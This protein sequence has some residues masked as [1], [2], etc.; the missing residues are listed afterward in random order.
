LNDYIGRLRFELDPESE[1]PYLQPESTDKPS[2]TSSSEA[3]GL[4]SSGS[5]TTDAFLEAS[6][7]ASQSASRVSSEPSPATGSAPKSAPES[8]PGSSSPAG[9]KSTSPADSKVAPESYLFLH[10][11]GLKHLRGDVAKAIMKSRKKSA[12]QRDAAPAKPEGKAGPLSGEVRVRSRDSANGNQ[13]HLPLS[14]TGDPGADDASSHLNSQRKAL[15][16]ALEAEGA[17]L[18]YKRQPLNDV[19]GITGLFSMVWQR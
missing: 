19:Q 2:D 10:N 6:G 15:D 13:V 12:A 4:A 8:A 14:Q 18:A 5:E 1:L 7:A 9:P 17:K 11:P 16:K 3:A